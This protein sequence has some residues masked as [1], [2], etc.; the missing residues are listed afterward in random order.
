MYII[1]CSSIKFYFIH[2]AQNQTPAEATDVHNAV[3]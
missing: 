2:P 3:C 1:T